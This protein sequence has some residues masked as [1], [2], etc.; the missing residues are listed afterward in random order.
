M[1]IYPAVFYSA[2]L[3]W[4]L[5]GCSAGNPAALSVKDAWMRPGNAGGNSAVYFI[6]E[7]TS[8]REDVLQSAW[9]DIA[10]AYEQHETTV[11]SDGMASM[12]HQMSIAIPA[13]EQVVFEPGGLHVMV[14]NLKRELIDGET[15]LL[16]LKFKNAGEIE[17]AVPVKQQ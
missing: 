11:S 8:D 15:I 9:G 13:G 4:I 6:V 3:A 5:S 7:N 14:I 12:H 2:T 16:R 17:L 1:K 10:E